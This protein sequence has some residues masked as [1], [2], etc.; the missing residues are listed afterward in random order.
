MNMKFVLNIK[1]IIKLVLREYNPMSAE[2]IMLITII[3]II[4]L[5]LLFLESDA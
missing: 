4:L 1:L 2:Q 3:K 5:S